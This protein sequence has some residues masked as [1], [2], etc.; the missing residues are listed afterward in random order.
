[1]KSFTKV[2]Q[3]IFNEVINVIPL[4]GAPGLHAF[5]VSAKL[6]KHLSHSV[7]SIMIEHGPVPYAAI[8]TRALYYS[9]Q[10]IYTNGV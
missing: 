9:S 4:A 7:Y 3:S 1:M 6:T 2:K 8:K 5:I 10:Q